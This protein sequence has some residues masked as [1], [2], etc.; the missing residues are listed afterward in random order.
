MPK[1]PAVS[2][3]LKAAVGKQVAITVQ[4]DN[5][6]VAYG[7]GGE[8]VVKQVAKGSVVLADSKYGNALYTVPVKT[9]TNVVVFAVPSTRKR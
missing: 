2:T 9:I 4:H 8:L 7:S 3:T 6:T 5:A 1:S